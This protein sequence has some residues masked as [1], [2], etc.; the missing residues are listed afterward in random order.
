[1]PTQA[2]K[3]EWSDRKIETAR[4]LSEG[5]ETQTEIAERLNL[6]QSTISRWK[7]DPVFL[8]KVDGMTLALERH[9]LA[10]MLRRIDSK[11][12]LTTVKKDEWT[13]LE[14]TKIK[15]LGFDKV[16]VDVNH[17]GEI[18][19]NEIVSTPDVLEAAN[20]LAKKIAESK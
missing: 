5:T 14:K 11:Q 10:G 3:G 13:E 16:K 8:K 1:M 18:T 15:L 7:K 17:S 20:N 9:S 2:K 4:A 12:N 19:H 6:Q